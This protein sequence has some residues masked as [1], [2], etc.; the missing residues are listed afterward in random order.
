MHGAAVRDLDET[1]SLLM[2]E[3]AFDSDPSR[4]PLRALWCVGVRL[5]GVLAVHAVVPEL[6][7]DPI[8]RPLL[9]GRVHAQGHRRAAPERAEQQ[10]VGGH[11]G[12]SPAELLRLVAA[13]HVVAGLEPLGQLW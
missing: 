8:Q 6:D 1:R 4:D 11:A 3:I 13:D 10:L 7:R 5:G 2:I 9:A 12:V